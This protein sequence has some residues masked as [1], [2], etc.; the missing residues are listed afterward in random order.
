MKR[1][2]GATT[3]DMYQ[4][5]QGA[6]YT[7]VGV[8]IHAGSCR[9]IAVIFDTHDL[10]GSVALKVECPLQITGLNAVITGSVNVPRPG[11]RGRVARIALGCGLE[12]VTKYPIIV[13]KDGRYLQDVIDIADAITIAVA[14]DKWDSER[15]DSPS[16]DLV[17]LCC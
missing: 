3:W 10:S 14:G 7:R 12:A 17:C 16:R 8:Q 1:C 13:A 4:G 9:R 5:G 11:L 2:K 6:S 15:I